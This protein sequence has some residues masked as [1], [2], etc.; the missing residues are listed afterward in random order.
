MVTFIYQLHV[1]LI[2]T[3]SR[4]CGLVFRY[5]NT[6]SLKLFTLKV[7]QAPDFN[8]LIREKQDSLESVVTCFDVTENVPGH[9]Q[10]CDDR[11]PF[12]KQLISHRQ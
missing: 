2:Y 12:G 4:C 5:I 8:R 7:F 1:N 9:R 10:P 11:Q 3:P 6:H